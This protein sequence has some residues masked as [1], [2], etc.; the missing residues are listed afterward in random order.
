MKCYLKKEEYKDTAIISSDI[1]SINE[2]NQ[3]NFVSDT[4]DIVANENSI[5]N[6]EKEII[7]NKEK[8]KNNTNNCVISNKYEN[9][10]NDTYVRC[11]IYS[12]K[13]YNIKSSKRQC[14]DTEYNNISLLQS[15]VEIYNKNTLNNR[16]KYIINN[17]NLKYIKTIDTT[18][19]IRRIS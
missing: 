10:E 3:I 14:H 12:D 6:N 4:T 5:S 2:L 9:S 8:Y 15:L 19:R 11:C 13:K 1:K 7:I 18:Y 17:N 16:S